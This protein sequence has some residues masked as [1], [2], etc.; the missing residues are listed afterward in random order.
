M[1][2]E[3]RFY[4]Y[5][6]HIK[7]NL[8][9]TLVRA[10]RTTNTVL[11]SP[12]LLPSHKANFLNQSDM[13]LVHLHWINGEM[14]SLVDIGRIKKP[15]VWTLHD[16]WAFCGAEHYT[17]DFRWRD[18]Y[19]RVNRPSYE[20]GFD[21]NRWTWV[22]KQKHWQKPFQIVTPSH[23]L[24]GCVRASALMGDWPVVV[25]PNAL[26]MAQWQ[27]V[28]KMIARELLGLPCDVPILLFGAMGGGEDPR[29]GFDLLQDALSHLRD[30]LSELQLLVFGQLPPRDEPDIGFPIH[31]TGHLH[32]ELS[33]RILYSAADLLVIP[34]RQDN[35]PNTGVEALACATPVVAF[36]T[37]GLPDIVDHKKNGY[38]A[39]AFDTGDLAAGIKWVLNNDNGAQLSAAAREK[40]VNTFDSKLVAQQYIDLY[41]E[42]LSR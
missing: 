1:E 38:L 4:K 20:S 23:W 10:L 5:L 28:N 16:M 7:A 3:G 27:P 35:L 18:G 17:E 41:Q 40:A 12:A 39:T 8:A 32:D 13:D 15:V 26:D 34:S 33:L 24:A 37:C 25:I 21:L 19:Q 30:E 11:H 22:R 14:L 2:P 9:N 29:K 36:D 6:T 31:Y 42:V